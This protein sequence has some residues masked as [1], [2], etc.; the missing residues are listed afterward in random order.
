[1]QQVTIGLP[2]KLKI[3]ATWLYG[4]VCGI[5]GGKINMMTPGGSTFYAGWVHYRPLDE[6][7]LKTLA[8]WEEAGIVSEYEELPQLPTSASSILVLQDNS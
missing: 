3:H 1:M 2:V 8:H 5:Q 7:D 6:D 4:R